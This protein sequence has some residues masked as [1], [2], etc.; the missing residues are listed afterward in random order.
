MREAVHVLCAV[1]RAEAVY[2]ICQEMDDGEHCL[3][4][5]VSSGAQAVERCRHSVPDILVI[6]AVLPEMDGLGVVDLLHSRLG[7]RMPRV[8]GGAAST[9][10]Y[11]GFIRRGAEHV[12]HVPWQ[13]Q[14]LRSVLTEQIRQMQERIDWEVYEPGAA[15]AGLLLSE[16][17]MNARLK[18]V[19]Y[20]SWAAALVSGNE[21]RISA[22]GDCVYAPVAARFGTTAQNVERLIRHAIESTMSAAQAKGMYSLFGNTIDPAKGKPTNAQVI[23]LL[24]QRMRVEK[25]KAI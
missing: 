25:S 11:E 8:V 21:G 22:V 3:F 24:A 14:E 9:F 13:E 1:R 17:G 19:A 2:R 10:S 6:D 12:I 16:M 7:C 5:I 18:G 15:Q 23:A 4:D 20:L